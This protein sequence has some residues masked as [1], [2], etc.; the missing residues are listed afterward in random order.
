[1]VIVITIYIPTWVPLPSLVVLGWGA[2]G[3]INYFVKISFY[4]FSQ[5]PDPRYGPYLTHIYYII[6]S[7][8][9]PTMMSLALGEVFLK[10]YFKIFSG[11]FCILNRYPVTRKI[12]NLLQT[13]WYTYLN[14][15]ALLVL[16]Q[17]SANFHSKKSTKYHRETYAHF[18]RSII[19]VFL[20]VTYTNTIK[21]MQNF[22]H[23]SVSL[24]IYKGT[25]V[26]K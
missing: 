21:S 6:Y 1:V 18:I 2:G 9:I 22:F 14:I 12:L 13:V 4:F 10:N 3:Q 19:T 25:Y 8:N 26:A 23:I 15:M 11:V 17:F 5:P 20:M 7:T 16:F 24:P